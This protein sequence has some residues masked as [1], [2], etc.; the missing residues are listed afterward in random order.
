MRG[1]LR[2]PC[3][4]PGVIRCVHGDKPQSALKTVIGC[5]RL[6]GCLDLGACRLVATRHLYRLASRLGPKEW[7]NER[8]SG[9]RMTM[10]ATFWIVPVRVVGGIASAR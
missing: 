6:N 3:T 1:Y 7:S 5:D 8:F 10:C 2:A 4:R 9:I